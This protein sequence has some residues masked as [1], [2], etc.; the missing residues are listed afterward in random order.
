MRDKERSRGFLTFRQLHDRSPLNYAVS[1]IT[2]G[3]NQNSEYLTGRQTRWLLVRTAKAKRSSRMTVAVATP[4]LLTKSNMLPQVLIRK[5]ARTVLTQNQSALRHRTPQQWNT[6]PI[7]RHCQHL[8]ELSRFPPA[9]HFH[10]GQCTQV[11]T[12]PTPGSSTSA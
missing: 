10:P 9:T 6:V 11:V 1:K 12:H 5:Q 4:P 7:P 3:T 2:V 8:N